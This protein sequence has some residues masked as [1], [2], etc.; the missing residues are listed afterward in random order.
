M[1]LADVL[2]GVLFVEFVCFV[3]FIA[4]LLPVNLGALFITFMTLASTTAAYFI[5]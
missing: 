2:L 4:C 5:L 3:V 1:E